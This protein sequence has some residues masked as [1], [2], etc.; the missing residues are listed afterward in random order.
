MPGIKRGQSLN[1]L[2]QEKILDLYE[3][4]KKKSCEKSCELL[5]VYFIHRFPQSPAGEAFAR[6]GRFREPLKMSQHLTVQEAYRILGVPKGANASIVR[7]AHRQLTKKF[8]PDRPEG[9]VYLTTQL[10]LARD[11]LLK[12]AHI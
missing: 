9:S 11:L 10:N 5:R 8:H 7:S 2:S 3:I 4:F 12:K 6:N 1:G